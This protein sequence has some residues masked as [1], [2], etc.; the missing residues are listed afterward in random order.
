MHHL[1]GVTA[2]LRSPPLTTGTSPE[3]FTDVVADLCGELGISRLAAVV[4][5]SAGGPT[6]VALASRHPNLVER[7]ILQSAV[8][9][10]PWPTGHLHRPR[11][12][13]VFSARIENKTWT[14]IHA[15]VHRAPDTALRLLLG[16]LTH[17]PLNP[18]IAALPA[19]HRTLPL[20]LFSQMRSG[21]GFTADLAVMPASPGNTPPV[22]QPTLIIATPH[23]GTVPFTHARSHPH[24]L[25]EHQ[26]AP[27]PLHLAQP[28]LPRHRGHHH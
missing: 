21:A 4:G 14:L 15:L 23:D 9:F 17:R 16:D 13:L 25:P 10:L 24:R 19:H 7:L 1:G 11:A 22:T 2:W 27:Q 8:G 5:Q 12:R 6:A 26:P 20:D 28:R 18:V 3:G